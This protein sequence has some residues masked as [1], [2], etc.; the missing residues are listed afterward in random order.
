MIR[1]PSGAALQSTS[2]APVV[3]GFSVLP[4]RA[5]LASRRERGALPGRQPVRVRLRRRVIPSF[6]CRRSPGMDA[7]REVN[8]TVEARQPGPSRG[9]CPSTA[10]YS[11]DDGAP[12]SADAGASCAGLPSSV[13]IPH[14]AELRGSRPG[15]FARSCARVTIFR[16]E[17]PSAASARSDARRVAPDVRPGALVNTPHLAPWIANAPRSRTRDAAVSLDAADCTPRCLIQTLR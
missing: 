12:V 7:T 2:S 13:A 16:D 15:A 6:G 17:R 11:S 3:V 14:C 8:E 4:A 1:P 9:R 10:G 5:N